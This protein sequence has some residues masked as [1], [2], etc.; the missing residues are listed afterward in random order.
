MPKQ[1]HR[2]KIVGKCEHDSGYDQTLTLWVQAYGRE[3]AVAK[4]MI[5]SPLISDAELHSVEVVETRTDRPDDYNTVLDA[6]RGE[7]LAGDEL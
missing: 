3:R 5:D 4:A 2:L 1:W 6:D 7:Y